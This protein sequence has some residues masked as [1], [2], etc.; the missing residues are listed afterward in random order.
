MDRSD[1]NG[2]GICFPYDV[3]LHILS[4]LPCRA[5]TK[6][7]QV[8]RAWR[9]I[10][11]AHKLLFP[12]FFPR[13]S[14]PGIFTNIYG[15]QDESSFF[16]PSAPA[17]SEQLNGGTHDGPVFRHPIFEHHKFSV[18]HHCNGLLLLE[19]N[20]NHNYYICN[21]ATVRCVAVPLLPNKDRWRYHDAMFLAFDPAVSPH[22][23]LFLLPTRMVQNAQEKIQRHKDVKNVEPQL[24]KL[25]EEEQMSEEDQDE[26]HIKGL[27]DDVG[28]SDSSPLPRIDVLAE[29]QRKVSPLEQQEMPG[30]DDQDKVI[31]ILVFSSQ[32][33]QWVSREFVPGRCALGALYD[34]LAAPHPTYVQ[35]WKSAEYWQ[36]SL[37]VHCWNNI[38]MILHN[39]N[40]VY[41][42][43]QL[44]TK[45]YDDEKYLDLHELPYRSI[46]ASHEGG[47]RYVALDKFQLHV[48]TLTE[49]TDG[50][51]G[52]VLAHNVDLSP[53]NH[54]VQWVM[55][56]SVPW[57]AVEHNKTLLSLFEPC[58]S[59]ELIDY[60]EDEQTDT[61]D[62]SSSRTEDDEE[63]I[64]EADEFDGTN[65]VYGDGPGEDAPEDEDEEGKFKS[66][67]DFKYSWDSDEDNFVDLDERAAPLGDEEFGSYRIIGLHPHKEVVLFRTI[68]GVVAYHLST[69]RMQYLGWLVATSPRQQDH[70]I[71][72]AFPYRP[73]YIDALP[74][75]K[76][77][78]SLL[79][80]VIPLVM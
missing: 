14:F 55:D 53:Y 20:F 32:T 38:I 56:P 31:S 54:Q 16:A 41:D 72:A 12:Y 4:R 47:V 52:W 5:L 33:N 51:I 75:T 27:F 36:G 66:D 18:R 35:I 40:G 9:S 37:Y 3:L 25:L 46:L 19:R 10:V 77:P 2:N 22:H 28:E 63:G 58:N 78:S 48:W 23:E 62:D 45:A 13:G 15:C 29:E 26:L 79:T 61:I 67:E 60:E 76:L 64:H 34:T 6:S 70:G 65:D 49:S 7:R 42:M 39:S 8:C 43:A 73:C 68:D 24:P 44:P 57:E 71:Y 1:G 30:A 74:T 11:D 69:S 21:P 59:K 50:Q 80:H 17:R